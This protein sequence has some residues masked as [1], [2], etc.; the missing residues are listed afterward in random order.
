M[1]KK[2]MTFVF[3]IFQ[4][5]SKKALTLAEIEAIVE[6]PNF[7]EDD[8]EAVNVVIMPPEDVD[9]ITDENEADDDET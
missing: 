7:W 8:P 3:F 9:Y 2:Q 4:M 1:F 6:D 5:N